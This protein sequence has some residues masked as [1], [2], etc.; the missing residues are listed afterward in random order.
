MDDIVKS[1]T[2]P[3]LCSVDRQSMIMCIASALA[4]YLNF[5][6]L[7][8]KM[9]DKQLYDT[10]DLMIDAHPNLPV[11]IIKAFAKECKKG[12]FGYH[13]DEMNGTRI[14]MWFNNYAQEYYKHVDD[15]EYAKHQNTKGDLANPIN[16]TD[17]EGEP[18]DWEELYSS[19]HGKTKEQ[20]QRERKEKEIRLQ[21]QK[22]H[23][24]LFGQMSVEE[25]DKIIEDAIIE[26]MKAQGLLTF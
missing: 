1:T 11:D 21:V 17:E 6:G 19:F 25:A 12:S 8:R 22:K 14:L 26:E 23:M 5:V 20:V 4:D 7:G 9:N 16:V 2:S 3:T 18:V 13:Y 24:H 10:A 15:Y